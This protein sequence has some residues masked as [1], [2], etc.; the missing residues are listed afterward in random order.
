[1]SS[2]GS[3]KLNEITNIRA[4]TK[5]KKD[6][7]RKDDLRPTTHRASHRLV[8]QVCCIS[9]HAKRAREESNSQGSETRDLMRIQKP[10]TKRKR[11]TAVF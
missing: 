10:R 1:M 5:K 4:S 8:M 7:N 11:E 9:G 2:T 3:L 6:E